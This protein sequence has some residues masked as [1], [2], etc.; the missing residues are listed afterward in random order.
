MRVRFFLLD[1]DTNASSRHRV[2]QY[3]PYLR[4]PGIQPRVGRPVPE[5]VYQR[6]VESGGHASTCGNGSSPNSLSLWERAGV[7]AAKPTFYGLFLVSR[8]LDVLRA[9][10]E[11]VVVIQR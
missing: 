7:R 11:D 6:L 8:L 4:Q 5:G 1:G 2:L 3:L 10:P 9:N